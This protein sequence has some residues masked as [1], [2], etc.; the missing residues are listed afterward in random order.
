MV[1]RGRELPLGLDNSIARSRVLI[2]AAMAA[3][4]LLKVGEFEERLAALEAATAG[5]PSDAGAAFP[6][7]L[8][9]P[10]R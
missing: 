10:T 1:G 5:K 4:N 6:A 3:T 8:P 2:A 9:E 7:E